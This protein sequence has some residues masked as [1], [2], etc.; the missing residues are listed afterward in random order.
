MKSRNVIE[1]QL[2]DSTSELVKMKNE[3][4]SLNVSARLDSHGQALDTAIKKIEG[5]TDALKW[6]LS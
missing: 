6:V 5:F 3:Y 4:N 2:D 1:K